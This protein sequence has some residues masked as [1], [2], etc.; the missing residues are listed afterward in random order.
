MKYQNIIELFQLNSSS[1]GPT[2]NLLE[3][4]YPYDIS[5]EAFKAAISLKE[6]ADIYFI[7]RIMEKLYATGFYKTYE[8]CRILNAFLPN[9]GK[10]N[11]ND[12]MVNI[13]NQNQYINYDYFHKYFEVIGD[14][15]IKDF[16]YN[17]I[18]CYKPDQQFKAIK[19]YKEYLEQNPNEEMRTLI[20]DILRTGSIIENFREYEI[21][22]FIS[23]C[24]NK[25]AK[26]FLLDWEKDKVFIFK[27]YSFNEIELCLEYIN[28]ID[29]YDESII[30]F[31][32]DF[33]RK[34]KLIFF[35]AKDKEVI[36]K[37]D[38]SAI[39]NLFFRDNNIHFD[40]TSGD[41]IWHLL[42]VLEFGAVCKKQTFQDKLDLVE[43]LTQ[44]PKEDRIINSLIKTRVLINLSGKEVINLYKEIEK[45]PLENP[46]CELEIYEA[47]SDFINNKWEKILTD[48]HKDEE[49]STLMYAGILEAIDITENKMTVEEFIDK[50]D[51]IKELLEEIKKNNIED[52]NLN[53]EIKIYKK[54]KN[55]N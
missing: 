26:S 23:L 21:K 4:S 22:R 17:D 25:Y 38:I 53:T 41:A 6:D 31:A 5:K 39:I 50:N 34:Y 19:V 55:N 36:K 27:I 49:L 40:L 7:K 45:Y 47:L 48:N 18:W 3:N 35:T 44:H 14:N 8:I 2:V 13:S 42:K 51:S 33:L 12:F 11:V 24:Q 9:Y 20:K 32:V 52:F 28:S 16:L 54:E 43:F 15:T 1:G 37:E 10:P 29:K 46:S 30:N